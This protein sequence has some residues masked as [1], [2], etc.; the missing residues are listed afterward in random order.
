MS[1]PISRRT[2]LRGAGAALAL[3]VLDAMLPGGGLFTRTVRAAQSAAASTSA[4]A[5]AV[6]PPARM[7]FA[8]IPNGVETGAWRAAGAA[9]S[10]LPAV[11]EPLAAHQGQFSIMTGLCHRNAE[12]LGDGPGDHARSGACFLTGAHPRKTAGGDIEAGI[13]V[14]QVAA[15][16]LRGRTRLDSLELGGEPGMTS[17]NCDSGYSCA[18]SA[19]ISWRGPHSPNGKDHDPRRVFERL[20]RDGPDGESNAMRSRRLALRQS[21]LDAMRGPLAA[22]NGRLGTNDRRKLDEYMEG[23][24]A[25]ER[26]I[27]FAERTEAEPESAIGMKRPEGIPKDYGEHLR[28]LADLAVLSLQTD[29]TR[30]VTFM[31][32]NEGSNRSYPTIGVKEGHHDVSHHGGDADKQRKF[33]AINTFHAE[34]F[35]YLLQR[36]RA[37]DD[38]GAPLLDSTMVLYGG[39]IADGNRHSHDDLPITLA[40]GS[41]LGVQ[42]A[43]R[44]TAAKGTPLCNLYL[45]MLDKMGVPASR[46]GDSSGVLAV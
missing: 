5:A 37:A 38:A 44:R 4:G 14:D 6:V 29:Q 27:E 1:A 43:P 23:V 11:L 2:V 30:V 24:R 28:L 19:N 21:I 12:A 25:I 13:S 8:F 45:G 16:H 41:K 34:Q 40:G 26:R 32:A 42:H 15:N 20:F 33:A 10:D 18:Y 46:F 17:G 3:P 36:L 7:L 22:L 35:A 39:A 31:L 9:G